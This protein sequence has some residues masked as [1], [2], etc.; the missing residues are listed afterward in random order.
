MTDTAATSNQTPTEASPAASAADTNVATNQPYTGP[1]RRSS[2][3]VWQDKVDR[4]LKDGDARMQALAT[5]LAENTKATAAIKADTAELV[6]LLHSVKGAF[7]VLDLLARMARPLGFLAAAGASFW[8]LFVA[9]KG[10]G[11]GPK[12]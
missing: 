7:R 6:D 10:G 4:R 2:L 3:R 1:E 8:G 11:G 12:L 9:I 5:D